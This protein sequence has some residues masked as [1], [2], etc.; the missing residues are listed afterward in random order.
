MISDSVMGDFAGKVK[1]LLGISLSDE[2]LR[3]FR[4]YE[5]LL[6]EWNR[7][8]S[9]TAI[10][11]RE[12]VRTK[13]FLDSLS[14]RKVLTPQPGTRII[15]IGTGAGFPGVPLKI[16]CPEIRLT[17]VD[18]VGKKTDFCRRLVN[19][20]GLI[21]VT[22]IQAR[23]EEVGRDPAHRGAYQWALARAVADLSVL[24]EYLLPLVTVGGRILAQK[25]AGGPAEVRSASKALNILG[26]A[27]E[28]V[29]SVDLPGI[30]ETRYLIVIRKSA[31]TPER[32][33]R[34]T[35]MPSKRPLSGKG[36]GRSK[37]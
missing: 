25:G 14:C 10:T 16:L 4:T 20:L 15:D 12:N 36:H 3:A 8:I 1:T 17:L 18:S 27:V 29:E 34:R 31:A 37:V 24:A 23:A 22:V 26:G 13:H 32:Y 33:P 5:D 21:N 11:G 19:R 7:R 2:Q 6:L 28:H 35:G 30:D 9:L